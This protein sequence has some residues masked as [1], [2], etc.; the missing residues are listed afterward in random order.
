[1][2][3]LPRSLSWLL[4][5]PVLVAAL[6]NYPSLQISLQRLLPAWTS[7]GAVGAPTV[8]LQQGNFVGTVLNDGYAHSVEGFIGIPYALPPVGELRFANPVPVTPSNQTFQATAFGPRCPGKQLRPKPGD[9]PESEDCLTV[10]VFRP[11]GAS[12]DKK[13]PVGL[14]I[15]GGAFNRGTAKMHDSAS[16]VGWS[17]EPFIV[18]S[19]NYRLGALGFLNSAL[20]AEEGLLNVGLKDQILMMEWVQDNIGAFGGDANDVTIFGLSAGA[21][22]IGHHVAN[23]NS[24]KTLFHKAVI[25][26]GGITSRAVHPYDSKL[27][28]TQFRELAAEV[29]CESK[30]DSEILACLRDASYEAITDG[31]GAV[32]AKYNPSVRWAWQPVIDGDIISR[33]PTDAWTSGKWNKVP[34]LTGFNHNEGTM[35]VPKDMSESDEFEDFFA[36]LLPQMSKEHVKQLAA[37]YPDPATDASSQYVETRPAAL[38]PQY[39]RV[40]AAY[41][42]YAYVCPVRQTAVYASTAPEDPPVFLYHWAQNRSVIAGANHADQMWYETMDVDVRGASPTQEEIAGYFHGYISSFIISGDPNAVKGRYGDR[43]EWKSY[44]DGGKTMQFGMGNDEPAGGSSI[45]VKAQL[46]KDDW[47]AEECKFWWEQSFSPED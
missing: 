45:G 31:Q 19:F 34:I 20:T 39:K 5:L 11:V 25:E 27:H 32:F 37:L 4:V 10:N 17:D 28:E 29:A 18:V 1:M 23:I 40:E 9:L 16:M 15:H 42:H 38:G 44:A 21:H 24:K 30:S 35:Y 3:S 6:L 41:G 22:S 33:R 26:S 12:S 36:T 14:Y 13:L 47:A 43:P 8:A 7:L 2:R 46:V